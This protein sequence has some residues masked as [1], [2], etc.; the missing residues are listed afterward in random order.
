[1][2]QMFQPN[3]RS[4]A[5]GLARLREDELSF[6]RS[7]QQEATIRS[8]LL[9]TP[10][11]PHPLSNTATI[12]TNKLTPDEMKAR[13]DKGLCSNCDEH[14]MLGHRC[15]RQMLLLPDAKAPELTEEGHHWQYGDYRWRNA[16]SLSACIVW[17][18]ISTSNEGE[19]MYQMT[20]SGNPY[21]LGQHS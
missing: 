16:R 2:V 14:F 6:S 12:P 17:I 4:A 18:Y 20:S 9:S 5:I 21:W 19:W 1:M 7:S 13:N 3:T 15:K 11:T 8:P 10:S